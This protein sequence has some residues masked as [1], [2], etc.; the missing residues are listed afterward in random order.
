LIMISNGKGSDE[1]G[2]AESEGNAGE[3]WGLG[4]SLERGEGNTAGRAR[5]GEKEENFTAEHRMWGEE[6]GERNR[7]EIG[8]R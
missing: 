8:Q 3:G 1:D 4:A 7:G 5:N 6:V 2:V